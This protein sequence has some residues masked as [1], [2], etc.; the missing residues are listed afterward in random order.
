MSY[1]HSL[2]MYNWFR[3]TW[4]SLLLEALFLVS[5]FNW[6]HLEFISWAD[7]NTYYTQL[8]GCYAIP[9][10]LLQT[11]TAQM[12]A[13]I[14]ICKQMRR[15]IQDKPTTELNCN[16][17]CRHHRMPRGGRGGQVNWRLNAIIKADWTAF[18][19]SARQMPE[20]SILST[21]AMHV[22]QWMPCALQ[23]TGYIL[24]PLGYH[25]GRCLLS[26]N[27]TRLE[28]QFVVMGAPWAITQIIICILYVCPIKRKAP[29]GH[30][31][32]N[33]FICT[34]LNAAPQTQSSNCNRCV[35]LKNLTWEAS[36]REDDVPQQPTGEEWGDRAGS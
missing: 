12:L 9:T 34:D 17:L 20:M 4:S 31:Q 1:F 15:S 2:A 19:Y 3:S 18:T 21:C 8:P 7:I 10:T 24:C 36:A 14:R 33:N 25:R 22:I 11:T 32:G 23:F 28:F 30:P 16:P 5:D 27:Y 6:P 13:S 26:Y 29:T 35:H